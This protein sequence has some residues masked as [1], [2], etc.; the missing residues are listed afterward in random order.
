MARLPQLR[1]ELTLSAGNPSQEGAPTWMLHDPAANRFFQL[2]WPAFELLSRWP[3]DDAAAIVASVNRDTTLSV[4]LADVEALLRMLSQ[5]N[6]LVSQTSADT[7]R[8]NAHAEAGRLG[9]AMWLLKHYLMIRIPLWHPMAFLRRTARFASFAYLPAFWAVVASCAVVGLFLVSRRWDEFV[10]TFHGYA[11]LQGVIAVG[12]ALGCAKVLHEFAH[13]FT[14]Q[15]YGCRVPTMGVAFLVMLP[16][17]YTDTTEAWKVPSRAQRLRIGAAGMLSEIAL[18]AFA[19]LA[20]SLLPDG[21]LKAGA[22][23]LATTTWIGTLA[24]NA[25]PFMR[26]D[27]YFLLS[28]WLDT[29]NLHDR[30]FAL[31]RWWLREQLFGFGD[32]QPEPCAPSRRRFLIGFSFA[33]WLYRLVVFFSIALVVYHAFFKVLGLALF[34]VEFGWFIVR[35]MVREVSVCWKRRVELHWRK[36]TKRTAW[37]GALLFG[38]VFLPWHAGVNAPAVFGPQ[39]AQGLYAVAAGYLAATPPPAHDGQQVHAGDVLGVLVSPELDYR[40]KG[41]QADETLLRWQVE[42]QAFDDRLREQGVALTKRWDAA[43]QT[44]AGLQAEIA[45]LTIRAPFSGTLQIAGDTLAPGTWLPRGEHLF[46]VIGPSGVKGDAFV[47]ENDVTRI[48][49]GD[50]ATFVASLSEMRPVD[51]KVVAIDKVNVSTLDEPSVASTYGGPIPAEQDAKTHQIVPLQATWRVRIGDCEAGRTLG[52]ELGGAVTLGAGRE[53][54]AGRWT[55]ALV[56]IV[57]REAG[58]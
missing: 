22:F 28:D 42:Q 43:R 12:V 2:G 57:Q 54:Y 51:C 20:W 46:D 6:L 14:A 39:Q 38:L 58:F 50:R 1:Q 55:R 36:E 29:P 34:C 18:A 30:A 41:A 19:T 3:L 49:A 27:G 11:D 7:A 5:Q 44:V 35:P 33:T 10:H 56:A 47:D 15:R 17:L 13:A 25:S 8:L 37:L 31:G 48:T 24:I 21:P 52:R 23:L 26:F 16:V 4:S 32:P 40:L 53:S 9:Q 45:Q